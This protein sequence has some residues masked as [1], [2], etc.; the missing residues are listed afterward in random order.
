[1]QFLKVFKQITDQVFGVKKVEQVYPIYKTY[2]QLVAEGKYS[3]IPR[4]YRVKRN[5][6]SK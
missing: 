3:S 5:N 6:P 1:M 4:C 2:T